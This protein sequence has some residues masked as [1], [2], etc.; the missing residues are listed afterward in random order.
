MPEDWSRWREAVDLSDYDRRWARMAAAGQNPHGEADFVCRYRPSSVLD[1]GCGTGRVGIELARRGISVAGVD[2][3]QDMIAAAQAKAP[4]LSWTCI[5]L[6]VF[7]PDR[8]FDLVVLAGN[9]I[10][11]VAAGSRA[12]AVAACAR[13]LV[14]G[15]RQVAGFS[16]RTGWPTV[17]DY[18]GWCS[19]AGLVVEDRFATWDGDPYAGGDYVVAVHRSP[20]AG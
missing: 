16:L 12:D 5:D 14:P 7:A 1:A 2:A 10:P 19:S 11:Y 3:D 9:V 20:A 6:A 15:G 4:E 18:E 17:A 13:A 8:R